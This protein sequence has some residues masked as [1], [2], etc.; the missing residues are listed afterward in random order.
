LTRSGIWF[1]LLADGNALALFGR[2]A[3]AHD[4]DGNLAVTPAFLGLPSMSFV[5][6]GAAPPSNLALLTAGAELQ[7]RNGWSVLGKLDDEWASRA[8]TYTGTARVR[9]TW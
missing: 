3:W 2:P 5:I 6:N 9:Y 7:L 8:H 1:P 4:R